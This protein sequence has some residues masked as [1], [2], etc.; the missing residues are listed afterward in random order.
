M[1]I[2][3]VTYDPS[4]ISSGEMETVLKRAGTYRDTFKNE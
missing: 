4:V 1:E 3:T 2:N